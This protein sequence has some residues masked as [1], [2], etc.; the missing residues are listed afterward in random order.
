M[1]YKI[2]IGIIA[3]VLGII[4]YVPYIKDIFLGKTKPHAFSWFIWSLI[5]FIGFAA[6][7]S[8]FAGPGAWVN[9]VFAFSCLVIFIFALWKGEKNILFVDWVNLSCA[10]FS[11]F[12]WYI[13]QSPFLSVILIA[14]TDFFGFLPTIRK[15]YTKPFEETLS[16]YAISGLAHGISLFALTH[17]SVIT[18]FY[19]ASLVVTNGIFVSM[20]LWR[21]RIFRNI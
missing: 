16:T 13:T 10:L 6:Q 12:L 18:A 5:S 3:V 14:L 15:S 19:P 2:I 9:F 7:V 17:Y 20:V 11:L 1:D 8:D 21:R 4:G